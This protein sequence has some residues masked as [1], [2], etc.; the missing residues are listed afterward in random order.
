MLNSIF[1]EVAK[2][3]KIPEEQVRLVYKSFIDGV[4][5]YITNPM[6]SKTV[7]RVPGIGAFKITKRSAEQSKLPNIQ[8]YKKIHERQKQVK[9]KND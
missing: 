1:K 6:T 2:K 7:I 9:S 8:I 5:F 3:K 4:R